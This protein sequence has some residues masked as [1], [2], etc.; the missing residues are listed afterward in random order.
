M[1]EYLDILHSQI[2]A[3]VFPPLG[4]IPRQFVY[5][6]G[7]LLA[8]GAALAYISVV[9]IVWTLFER[10]FAGYIQQRY[11]PNRT[12]WWGILQPVADG[13][14]LLGKEDIV[15]DAADKPIYHMAPILVFMGAMLPF[16]ALPF[17]E[18]L[19]M[20]GMAAGVLFILAFEA[21][22]VVGILM[23]GWG[24]NS[25]WSLYGGMRLASQMLAYEIPMGLCVLSVVA[26]TGSMNLVEIVELQGGGF[27]VANWFVWPWISPFASLAFVLFFVAGLASTK[28]AP[29][30]LPE[31][32]S[33]LVAGFHTEYTG[34]RFAFFFMAEY[35]SMYVVS[36]M[37]V[38]CFLG[39]WNG[40]FRELFAPAPDQTP[41]IHQLAAY[42]SAEQPAGWIAWAN[43]WGAMRILGEWAFWKAIVYQLL[44]VGYLVGKAWALLFVMVWVRW[45][46][47]R[48]RIDQVLH[49][50]LKV[51]LPFALACVL[52]AAAQ[53]VFLDSS[54]L[55][56]LVGLFG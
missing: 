45:T 10:K 43:L 33:E 50:C 47:P 31:A 9:S 1:Q 48:I 4:A 20:A 26:L 25:K 14:K 55:G 21:I 28:R 46:L 40:P 42:A 56:W 5:L 11:G 3:H 22:E 49:M 16:A 35:A 2:I 34:M 8:A 7:M 30:D 36:A 24:P 52:G 37:A 38:I 19:V 51:L 54:L 41:L 32:E 29:F 39:G 12:G 53:L 13:I 18:K 15:P 6:G 17:S 23:A 27:G 44:G